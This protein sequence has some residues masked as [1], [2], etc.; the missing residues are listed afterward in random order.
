[1]RVIGIDPGTTRVGYAILDYSSLEIRV[2]ACG[3]LMFSKGA[4][5]GRKSYLELIYE[6]IRWLCKKYN[7][8][9]AAIEKVFFSRNVSS[10][11]SVSEARGVI[12]LALSHSGVPYVG[13]TPSNVKNSVTGNGRSKKVH[14]Q[15]HVMKM[16]CIPSGLIDDVYDAIAI[17]V[18]HINKNEK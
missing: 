5:Q 17:A 16:L 8:D 2:D 15:R 10:A 12:L 9:S 7:P 13:Y 6:N 3:I 4:Y 14:V 18:T 1:M 11:I